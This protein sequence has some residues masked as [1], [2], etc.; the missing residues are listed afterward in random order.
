MALSEEIV[1][2]KNLQNNYVESIN[3]IVLTNK[4]V[5]MSSSRKH[6]SANKYA[7]T[8]SGCKM[9][10]LF[11]FCRI[12]RSIDMFQ[13]RIVLTESRNTNNGREMVTSFH[14]ERFATIVTEVDYKLFN[15]QTF[16]AEVTNSNISII[17]TDENPEELINELN[18]AS[19]SIPQSVV[20]KCPSTERVRIAYNVFTANVLFGSNENSSAAN[21]IISATA[22]SGTIIDG[23]VQDQVT[24]EMPKPEVSPSIITL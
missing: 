17:S 15:N 13:D 18:K 22:C 19:I 8:L 12:L 4:E 6:N 11:S 10:R 16:V 7:N 23:L 1:D 21:I 20:S 9:H 3:N 5:V 24:I 14:K 2:D